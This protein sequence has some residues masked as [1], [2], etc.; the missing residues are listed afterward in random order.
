[1]TSIA[2]AMPGARVVVPPPAFAHQRDAWMRSR[3]RAAF[4]L[5]MEMGTG[6]T[7]VIIDTALHLFSKWQKKPTT[8]I[9]GLLV[10][11]DN[12]IHRN[13]VS[14]EMAMHWPSSVPVNTVVWS[15]GKAGTR[16]LQRALAE[17]LTPKSLTGMAVLAM[18]IDAMITER[19]FATAER[20]L[21]ARRCL[22]FV[23]ESTSIKNH[24]A[25]RTKACTRLGTFA[26]YRRIA[27]GNPVAETP[28]DFYA[29][30][31]FLDAAILDSPSW[32]AFR[33]EYAY[34]R[35][36]YIE[37][38]G[39]KLRPYKV[40]VVDEKTGE[41]KYR[42]IPQ[43]LKRIAPHSYTILK[44]QCL[45]L[46][47]KLFAKR[48]V[49]LL[50]AQ[51]KA[52]TLLRDQFLIE[53][54]NLSDNKKA[55][56][57]DNPTLDDLKRAYP[58]VPVDL[59]EDMLSMGDGAFADNSFAHEGLRIPVPVA[60]VRM[61][62]L[63]QIVCGYEPTLNEKGVLKFL[64]GFTEEKNPRI[65]ALAAIVREVPKDTQ[66]IIWARFTPDIDQIMRMAK[67]NDIGAV[68]YD[69]QVAEHIRDLNKKKFQA[70]DPSARL[71]VANPQ[72]GGKGLTLVQAST[73]VFYSNFFSNFIRGQAED[74]AHRM[75]LKHA[76]TY[77]DMVAPGTV[78]E[79]IIAH[80]V[81][82]KKLESSI[83]KGLVEEWL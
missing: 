74:R 47:P 79:K 37:L 39:G 48:Y 9:N 32:W 11:A 49:P 56:T 38:P 13:F 10:I 45:D 51:Q 20:F 18:N 33:S 57:I 72:V 6:K 76:V 5:F 54:Q 83:M 27:T 26:P 53:L 62:R 70:S 28:L 4:A 25:K 36:E 1:M 2:V 50:P 12:G 16:G 69:G 8:G 15:T 58:G 41:K 40:Q 59:L 35:T 73:V 17:Q 34:W 24:S 19:G 30:L 60:M 75:G 14:D 65:E 64:P 68:R 23:D 43:L 77:I 3:D 55:K 31:A 71:F 42:N 22:M 7:R 78:D 61:L 67:E 63:Q 81:S 29:P 21:R 82:K 44:E 46:P 52:Y 66:L 80:L